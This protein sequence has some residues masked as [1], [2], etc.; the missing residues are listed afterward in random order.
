MSSVKILSESK[1]YVRVADDV[2][3]ACDRDRKS[4]LTLKRLLRIIVLI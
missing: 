4:L 1:K 2:I 3:L